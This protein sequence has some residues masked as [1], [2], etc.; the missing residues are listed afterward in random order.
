MEKFCD[1]VVWSK[2]S[3][4]ALRLP[5]HE[6]EEE[7][8]VHVVLGVDYFFRMLGSMIF[9]ELSSLPDRDCD[10][11]PV[12]GSNRVLTR[13]HRRWRDTRGEW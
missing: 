4:Q 11:R 12:R 8:P 3:I 5:D 10:G 6:S 13:L 7:L 9:R 1:N 2:I